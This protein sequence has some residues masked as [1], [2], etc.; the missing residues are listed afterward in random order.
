M[1]VWGR[2]EPRWSGGTDGLTVIRHSPNRSAAIPTPAANRNNPLSPNTAIAD[3]AR[4]GP[5]VAPAE[6]PKTIPPLADTIS[7]GVRKSLV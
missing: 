1:R 6:K 5:M 2:K 3:E 4:K 7:A